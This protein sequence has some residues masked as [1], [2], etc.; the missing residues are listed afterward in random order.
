MLFR[1]AINGGKHRMKTKI[2]VKGAILGL[3]LGAGGLSLTM[4][5]AAS[6]TPITNLSGCAFVESGNV[7][8]LQ[9]NCSSTQEINVPAGVTLDG[10]NYTISPT[11][12]YTN[13]SNNAV[14]GVLSSNVTVQNLTIDGVSGP[15][16]HGINIYSSTGVTI[17]HVTVKNMSRSGIV[18]NGSVVSVSN[19]TTA[20]NGW[21]G[22]DVDLGSGVTSPAVLNIVGLMTQT[23][24][25]Q[26]YVDDTRKTVTVNDLRHQYS[27]SH[28][29]VTDALY[30]RMYAT[31]K[32]ACKDGGWNLGLSATQSFKN[33]GQCVAH[34][35]STGEKP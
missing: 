1:H 4:S 9:S 22:I 13:N 24:L 25:A 19:V 17:N 28:P 30:T 18:V 33:Q 10:G 35:E 3:V 11:F 26:I 6:A 8:T 29:R 5:G 21:V 34:F 15:K 2:F 20:N 12:P 32:E 23:D 14:V 16:L 31:D 27:V 7:W